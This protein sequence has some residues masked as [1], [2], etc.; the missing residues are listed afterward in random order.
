MVNRQRPQVVSTR[1]LPSERQLIRALAEA[2]G[3]SV[4]EAIHRALLPAIRDRLARVAADAPD[5]SDQ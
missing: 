2:E 5:S 1:V 3:V 4:A